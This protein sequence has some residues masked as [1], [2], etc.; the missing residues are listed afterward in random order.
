MKFV[1][2]VITNNFCYSIIHENQIENVKNTAII[3]VYVHIS[4]AIQFAV[5][6]N[7]LN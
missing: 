6:I 4:W 5:T 3:T 1:I 7:V 2:G